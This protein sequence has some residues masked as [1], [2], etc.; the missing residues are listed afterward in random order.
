LGFGFKKRL[1]PRIAAGEFGDQL[2]VRR[3]QFL[4]FFGKFSLSL[5]TQAL[6]VTSR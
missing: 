2:L 5:G 1:F 3:G 6:L 4:R